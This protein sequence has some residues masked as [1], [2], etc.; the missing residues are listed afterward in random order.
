MNKNALE[1]IKCYLCALIWT[2][3]F[4][5][6]IV[7]AHSK[8]NLAELDGM[9]S[10]VAYCSHISG[11]KG[12][13]AGR[14]GDMQEMMR[15]M[16]AAQEWQRELI[17][18][19][20]DNNDKN[21][22]VQSA[23]DHFLEHVKKYMKKAE[24]DKIE[25][26]KIVMSQEE[27]GCHTLLVKV[28]DMPDEK[29]EVKDEAMPVNLAS[30]T[31]PPTIWR[32]A[33]KLPDVTVV[34]KADMAL[35]DTRPGVKEGIAA[36]TKNDKRCIGRITMHAKHIK[37]VKNSFKPFA[38][39]GC[40]EF[41]GGFFKYQG[42]PNPKYFTIIW[43]PNGFKLKTI[44]EFIQLRKFNEI[45]MGAIKRSPAFLHTHIAAYLTNQQ[46]AEMKSPEEQARYDRT[47][48][49]VTKQL[50]QTA[51]SQ[52]S[53]SELIGVWKGELV[54]EKQIL[55]VEL[56]IWSANV[57]RY[58][59]L[60][61]VATFPETQCTTGL[62]FGS[63]KKG[64]VMGLTYS[65]VSTPVQKCDRMEVQSYVHKQDGD[66]LHVYIKASAADKESMLHK[67]CL[68]GLPKKGCYTAGILKRTN[69]SQKLRKTMKEAR[70]PYSAPPSKE[71]WNVIRDNKKPMLASLKSAH[72][73]AVAYN[74]EVTKQIKREDEAYKQQEIAK[75]RRE[76][77]MEKQQ[78]S[79]IKRAERRLAELRSGGS[80]SGD[81]IMREPDKVKGPF[82]AIEG[83]SFFNAIYHGDFSSVRQ[84]SRY[85][86]VLKSKQIRNF[87]GNRNDFREKSIN[88][89]FGQVKMMNIFYA[90]YLKA[91][92]YYYKSCLRKD[93]ETFEHII[94]TPGS[95]TTDLRGRVMAQRDA[96]RTVYLYTVNKEFANIFRRIGK[97][98]PENTSMGLVDLLVG[99]GGINMPKQLANADPVLGQMANLLKGRG[100]RDLRNQVVTGTRQMMNKFSCGSPEIKQLERN[101]LNYN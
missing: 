101:M 6:P 33:R 77:E 60:V 49:S 27:A 43:Y 36:L 29:K 18:F 61:G 98:N 57:S 74:V 25:A 47:L 94:E 99:G 59:R 21:F 42:H 53:E 73:K 87:M 5:I 64:V 31:T 71:T 54:N 92:G 37:G 22:A 8:N 63:D 4:T 95:I 93:A 96:T 23:A 40:S 1:T 41:E 68:G 79:N 84:Q 97:I 80:T 56:A 83:A 69:A 17:K 81:N 72:I 34:Q 7:E 24:V 45:G 16:Q 67:G 86:Q 46:L 62:V 20:P 70:W 88:N 14:K 52:F 44:Q 10:G 55:P 66:T 51:K 65:T 11:L 2:F 38:G 58:Q 48:G 82:D 89:T 3:I 28:V 50:K 91:Y 32:I 30:G 12:M 15:F 76:I 85:Y 100:K 75:Y 9:E 19:L 35:W 26:E 39:E 90:M 13:H 78:K